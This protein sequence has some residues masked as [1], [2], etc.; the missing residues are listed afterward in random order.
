MKLAIFGDL[1]PTASNTELFMKGKAEEIF[2]DITEIIKRCDHSMF[3]LECSASEN[4][5]KIHK[6]GPHLR[7]PT[8]YLNTIANAG[9]DIVAVANNHAFDYGLQ[10]FREELDAI[11]KVGMV[12]VG[13]NIAE[14]H[15]RF[16]IIE[17]DSKKVAILAVSDR[18]FNSNDTGE[19]VSIFDPMSTFDLIAEL[20]SQQNEIVVVYHT[21]MENFQYPSP[22]LMLRCRK[23]VEKGASIVICQHSHCIG[24]Y[25]MYRGGLIVYGQGNFLFDSTERTSWHESIAIEIEFIDDEFEYRFVPL[26]VSNGSVRIMKADNALLLINDLHKRSEQ[27]LQPKSVEQLWQ[28]FLYEQSWQYNAMMMGGGKFSYI[29]CYLFHRFTKKILLSKKKKRAIGSL[30]RSDTHREAIDKLINN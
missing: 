20:K 16:I 1:C 25:E 23:M 7:M 29:I 30:L 9:F 5:G 17:D 21:G 14:Q 13:S 2:G 22:G 24:T 27:I 15:D 19:G 4:G 8:S 12:S 10:G 3:N 11:K 6:N 28:K 18:E 26:C